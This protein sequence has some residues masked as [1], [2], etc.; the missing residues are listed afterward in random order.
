MCTDHEFGK[1]SSH[2]LPLTAE[3]LALIVA[4]QSAKAMYISESVI[5]EGLKMPK[6][7]QWHARCEKLFI[8]DYRPMTDRI[9]LANTQQTLKAL[10]NV[11]VTEFMRIT[12][13]A[14]LPQKYIFDAWGNN[15]LGVI[16]EKGLADMAA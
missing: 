11:Q 2:E 12:P 15:G 4:M 5:V 9:G 8:V 3:L 14:E 10:L 16:V 7:T 13:A 6:L 1:E